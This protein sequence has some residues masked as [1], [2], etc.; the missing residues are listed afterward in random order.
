MRWGNCLCRGDLQFGGILRR[1]LYLIAV[2]FWGLAFP[3]SAQTTATPSPTAVGNYVTARD[4]YVR[5]GPS[6]FF[7]PV[8]RLVEGAEVR[9]LNL[10]ANGRWVLIQYNRGFGWI[11]R[12]LAVWS[13]NIDNLPPLDESQ[14]TPTSLASDTPMPRPTGIQVSA[15]EA[16][17]YVRFGPGVNFPYLGAVVSGEYV[18]PVGRNVEGDWILIRFRDGFGWVSRALL[19]RNVPLPNLPVL[20]P[21]ALTPSAT[22]P[23]SLTPTASNT[24][25]VTQTPSATAT[26]TLIPTNTPLPTRTL[27]VTE[28]LTETASVTAAPSATETPTPTNT[29]TLTPSPAATETPTPTDTS[30]LT[31]SLAATDTPAPSA[32]PTFAPTNTQTASITPRASRT[33]PPTATPTD[34][35]VPTST[36]TVTPSPT[37]TETATPTETAS[38]TATNTE[39]ATYTAAPSE[40]P[41]DAATVVS[42]LQVATTQLPSATLSPTE[43]PTSTATETSTATAT[44]TDTPLPASST[45]VQS[46]VDTATEAGAETATLTRTVDATATNTQPASTNETAETTPEAASETPPLAAEVA[47]LPSAS[48]EANE[49]EFAASVTDAPEATA[50]GTRTPIILPTPVSSLPQSENGSPPAVP[51]EAIVGGL[52]LLGLMIY[53][54][55]YWRGLAAS[56]RYTDGFV[57]QRCPVCHDGHLNVETRQSRVLGIPRPRSIVRCGTCRSVLREAGNH[58]WRYAVDPTENPAI[59]KR[60]NGKVIDESRLVAL[61]NSMPPAPPVVQSPAKPPVFL[62]DEE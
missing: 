44:A 18:D 52:F 14:L 51:P 53:V 59:Y 47:A 19:A 24:P 41:T 29:F 12:D 60:F 10:S 11:R 50:T 22:S 55:L 26:A 49:T 15:G 21:G 31:P 34:T 45:P 5:G 36:Y 40:T 25:T 16:G 6:E 27:G 7:L 46:I 28:V 61:E 39:T 8:G 57:I 20:L 3:V 17:A 13:D 4:I 30:T 56:D 2:C 62:D 33:S 32:M 38:A 48:V 42:A 23:A 58:R 1:L 35:D 43:T 37:L 9:P 54:G